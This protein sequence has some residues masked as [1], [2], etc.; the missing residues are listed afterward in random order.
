MSSETERWKWIGGYEG[1]YMVSDFG[2]VKSFHK[3]QSGRIRSIYRRCGDYLRLPLTD[4]KGEHRTFLVH[5]LVATAFI[6]GIPLGW[7]VHHI[8]GNKQNN[9]VSNLQIVCPNEHSIETKA[10]NPQIADGMKNYNRYVKPRE[11]R[12][13]TV[14]GTLIASYP[15]AK[16]ASV[17]TGVC[18]RNI[19]QVAS[20]T[21]YNSRGKTRKQAGGYVW[22]FAKEGD[23]Y[24]V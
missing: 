14:D 19:L 15:N 24:E 5:R 17:L 1:L 12:Q 6:G 13:Y 3:G 21:P 10:S 23:E 18:Q 2:R 20:Q 8:D 11:I 9:C 4:Q 22:K 16:E 7:Q